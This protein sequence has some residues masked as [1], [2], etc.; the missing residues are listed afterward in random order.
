MGELIPQVSVLAKQG[1]ISPSITDQLQVHTTWLR[2][3][4]NFSMQNYNEI[5]I[6]QLYNLHLK[7]KYGFLG[8][9]QIHLNILIDTNLQYI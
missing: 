7:N 6:R 3:T 9:L 4:K 5:T 2:T 1:T 8:M